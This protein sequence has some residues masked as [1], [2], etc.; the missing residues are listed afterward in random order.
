MGLHQSTLVMSWLLSRLCTILGLLIGCFLVFHRFKL[1]R[2]QEIEHLPLQP[3]SYGIAGFHL[4][5]W[6]PC[7]STLNKKILIIS[8]VWDSN[9]VAMSI[10]FCVSWDCV[11]TKNKQNVFLYADGV[12][13]AT[14][15]K[16][17]KPFFSRWLQ[18][19]PLSFSGI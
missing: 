4:T 2:L 17:L 15:R 9:M 16:F 3:Q 5:S 8:F 18:I 1:R 10:I 12:V 13:F 14:K 19:S 11:K 7:W 6:R